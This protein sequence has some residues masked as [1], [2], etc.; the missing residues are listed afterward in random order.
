MQLRFVYIHKTTTMHRKNRQAKLMKARP[1]I[2][3]DKFRLVNAQSEAM[4]AK[5]KFAYTCIS[6]MFGLKSLLGM[7]PD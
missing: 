1:Q 3:M 5:T 6:F 7:G 4:N 2:R